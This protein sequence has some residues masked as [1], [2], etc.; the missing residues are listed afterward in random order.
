MKTAKDSMKS[1]PDFVETNS[2]SSDRATEPASVVSINDVAFEYL[3]ATGAVAIVMGRGGARVVQAAAID[4][5]QLYYG[6]IDDLVWVSDRRV[7]R[8]IVR[9]AKKRRQSDVRKTARS[10]GTRYSEHDDTVARAQETAV[11]LDRGLRLAKASGALSFFNQEY[12]RRRRDAAERG[13]RFISFRKAEVR[14]RRVLIA[15]LARGGNIDQSVV[16]EVFH[17]WD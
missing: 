10:L 12:Q 17:A 4:R 15:R 3:A 11:E 13:V 16:D 9:T 8:R 1:R 6:A 7:A 14:F 2:R 5:H